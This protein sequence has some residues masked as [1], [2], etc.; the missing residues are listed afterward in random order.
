M[1]R[2]ESTGPGSILG[3]LFPGSRAADSKRSENL[4]AILA[5]K[6]NGCE[7]QLKHYF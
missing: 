4:A 3:V 1:S 6:N 7:I 2:Y 5:P